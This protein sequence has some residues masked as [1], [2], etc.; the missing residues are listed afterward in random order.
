MDYEQFL[1]RVRLH[2]GLRNRS[3]AESAVCAVTE[4]LGELLE[5]TH[6]EEIAAHLPSPIAQMLRRHT[7]DLELDEVAFLRRV[8][9]S[10]H[11]PEAFAIEQATSVL[12]ALA[13]ELEPEVRRAL[14]AQLPDTMH[15]WLVPRTS[16]PPPSVHHDPHGHRLA[17]GHPGSSHPI[18]EAKPQAHSGSIAASDDPHA[19][20][21]LSSAHGLT[22]EREHEDLAEGN[23]TTARPLNETR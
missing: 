13:E 14:A 11:R 6:R 17:D 5:H 2:S 22:Q 9:S 23:P 18:S 3:E 12:E 19:Q 10:V 15:R 16:S 1:D 7:P 20:T 4:A 21:R 8:A